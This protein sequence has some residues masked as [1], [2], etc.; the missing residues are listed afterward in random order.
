MRPAHRGGTRSLLN[1]AAG[2]ETLIDEVRLT[3]L[4]NRLLIGGKARA[5][6][7]YARLFNLGSLNALC[8]APGLA[9]Q[10]RPSAAKSAI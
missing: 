2:T 6:I 10:S 1:F 7:Q 8:R 9:S 4:R 5:L 3:Q